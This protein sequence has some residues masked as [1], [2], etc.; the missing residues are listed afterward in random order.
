MAINRKDPVVQEAERLIKK[1]I[2]DRVR[3]LE[4]KVK[5]LEYQVADLARRLERRD[6]VQI[7]DKTHV[8][9]R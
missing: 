9:N 8:A 3:P 5:S 7:S 1:G 4:Q 6:Q 2:D